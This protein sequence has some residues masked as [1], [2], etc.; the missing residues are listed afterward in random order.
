MFAYVCVY[1]IRGEGVVALYSTHIIV[2]GNQ[3]HI[4]HCINATLL[5]VV[6][7]VY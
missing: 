4:Y 5:P 7:I 1:T 2:Y 3:T 6:I